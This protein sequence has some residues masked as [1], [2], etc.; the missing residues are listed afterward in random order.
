MSAQL[1]KSLLRPIILA[2]ILVALTPQSA[3]AGGSYSGK[4]T[5]A[6]NGWSGEGYYFSLNTPSNCGGGFVIQSTFPGYTQ[7]TANAMIALTQS[8]NVS[9]A[10]TGT[11]SGES[12]IVVGVGI[13]AP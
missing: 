12:E 13:S 3:R 9:V 11:C 4:I 8:L 5:S 7:A 6:T 10:T 1:F 2:F